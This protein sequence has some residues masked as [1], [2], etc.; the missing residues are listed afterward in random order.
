MIKRFREKK[1]IDAVQFQ[2]FENIQEVISFVGIPVTAEF[3]A[4]GVQLRIIRSP[5]NVV[6]VK[7]GEYVAKTEDGTLGVITAEDLAAKYD[8]VTS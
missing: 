4:N 3:G 8:E 6:I 7:I 5:F 1:Y 2:N